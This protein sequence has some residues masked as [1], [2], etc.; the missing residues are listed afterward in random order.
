MQMII[1]NT[2]LSAWIGEM[3]A[4]CTP[5]AVHICDGSDAEFDRISTQMVDAGAMTRLNPEKR[6]N[7]FL[8]WS[9]PADVARLEH[10][11]FVCT[12]DRDEAGPTN[13]WADPTEM[14]A[15]LNGLFQGCMRGRTM[16]VIPFCMGPIG[17][18]HAMIGVQI[19][20]SPYVVISMKLMAYVGGRVLEQLGNGDFVRCMHSVGAPLEP[21]QADVAWP[22]NAEHKYIVSFQDDG[23]IA[24]FGSGYGGN[25]LL[26]K[27]CLSLRTASYRARDEGWLAEHML[28]VGVESPEGDTTYVAG[29]FPSACGKTN[30]AMMRTPE[31]MEGWT[32]KTIGDDIAWIRPGRDGR[33]WAVN[34]EAGFFG[35][36]P[37]TNAKTNPNIM[38]ALERDVI[39]T[40]C[41]LTEDG[42][43]WWEGL[44]DQPPARLTDWQGR[45]WTPD[46]G[47]PAAH[48][49]AR[50]TVSQD[51][52]PSMDPARTEL[53][54]V[55]ISAFIFGGRLSHTYPLVF[56]ARD[57][58]EGV[59][60]AA[61]LG[62]EA[63][64]AAEG[65]TGTRR[66]PFAMLPFCGYHMADYWGHWLGFGDR[67]ANPPA[68]FRVNWFRRDADGRF[69]WPGFGQNMRALKWIVQ[70]VKG[71]AG[72]RESAIGHVPGFEDLDWTGLT[73]DQ[74]QFQA[75]MELG[76]DGMTREL[77]EHR[78]L[79][80]SMGQR[81]PA[82]LDRVY[83]SM[84]RSIDDDAN[85]NAGAAPRQ[86]AMS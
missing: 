64:A 74:P 7:S 6:P 83:G 43:V 17:S 60:W 13:N 82:A 32:V 28:I 11:T 70:R 29:A 33:L 22:C 34:P 65:Q 4:L 14:R 30:F 57:W 37:G 69:M 48:P 50:F 80:D 67:L 78:A 1:D 23:S 36:A 45:D 61:T 24:S 46:C 68:M 49:N 58:T 21:G 40:N 75:L 20:D 62:S 10:R 53:D 12:T 9:D 76:H 56:Q 51:R 85:A 73:Y 39:F 16:Y 35:V 3:R 54:G 55:P 59:Y 47:R 31:G 66:D 81:L 26:G 38:A 77:A 25:A 5:E 63:T 84:T 8:C 52:A 79:F 71:Q 2:Q 41:A 86:P 18:E 27:K 44:T 15:R 19:T 72:A 42:D